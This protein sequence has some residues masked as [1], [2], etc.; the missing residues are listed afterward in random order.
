MRHNLY[1]LLSGFHIEEKPCI[2]VIRF[3]FLP[4]FKHVIQVTHIS[5]LMSQC[6]PVNLSRMVGRFE[7]ILQLPGYKHTQLIISD[8]EQ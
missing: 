5:Q 8:V 2:C 3:D 1:G 7:V 6:L 4:F